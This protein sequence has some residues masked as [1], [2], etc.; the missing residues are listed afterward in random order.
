MSNT[1]VIIKKA[2]IILSYI[3]NQKSFSWSIINDATA[4]KKCD[5][6]FF[7]YNITGVPKQ[8]KWFFGAEKMLAGEKK[9]I[10]LLYLQKKYSGKLE[11]NSQNRCR[12]S[13]GQSLFNAFKFS[14][15]DTSE[16]LPLVRFS[17]IDSNTY[18]IE[19]LNEHT[20]ENEKDDPFVS[21]VSSKDGKIM[22][23]YTTKY[24]RNPYNRKMAI[25]IHGIKCMACGF[26]FEEVY[27]AAGRDF[28]EVH[29][30]KPLSEIGSEVIID[31]EKDLVCLCANCHRI[32]H[33]HR[34]SIYT[35]DEVRQMISEGKQFTKY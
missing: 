5:K 34:S 25:A 6:T 18:S 3:I 8:I 13:W 21:I 17:R 33:R 4:I 24:E 19:V 7:E 14:Y 15:K 20:I 12:I 27:G 9:D 29:H 22:H 16:F 31:P 2:V 32:V 28:I 10:N 30:T 23:Y 26:D 11:I 1:Y 35:V